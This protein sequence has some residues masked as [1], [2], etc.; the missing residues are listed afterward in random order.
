MKKQIA[1]SILEDISTSLMD[2]NWKEKTLKTIEI[3][4]KGL[5]IA[6]NVKIKNMIDKHSEF[7]KKYGEN[8]KKTIKLGKKIDEEIQKIYNR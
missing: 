1:I 8:H 3:Y 4:R 7:T 5:E 6:T 2:N